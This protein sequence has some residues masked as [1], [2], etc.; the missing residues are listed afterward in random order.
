MHAL[1]QWAPAVCSLPLLAPSRS[2]LNS[3]FEESVNVFRYVAGCSPIN[4]LITLSSPHATPR[5]LDPGS[6]KMWSFASPA[7]LNREAVALDGH[8]QEAR[9]GLEKAEK[10]LKRS[11]EERVFRS[12]RLDTHHRACLLI[13]VPGCD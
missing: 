1:S 6:C 9:K 12:L 2:L 10:L 7:L 4:P 5:C 3:E 8:S 13:I 11:K